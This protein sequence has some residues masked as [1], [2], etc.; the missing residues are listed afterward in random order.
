MRAVATHR[1]SLRRHSTQVWETGSGWRD[2]SR[3]GNSR[4]QRRTTSSSDQSLADVG[5][6]AH[7][8]V[9]VIV[10]HRKAADRHGEDS[11]KFLQATLDPILA[12][13]RSL[14][15]PK[16]ERA[17]HTACNAVIPAG[18]GRIDEMARAMVMGES[19]Q[20]GHS[21]PKV[22]SRVDIALH[23]LAIL[24]SC[25]P[26]HLVGCC[27]REIDAG[28]L[29]DGLPRGF[30]AGAIVKMWVAHRLDWAGEL[31]GRRGEEQA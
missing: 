30:L 13:T 28:D 12:A 3:G 9:Q 31:L 24:P 20:V 26:C 14:A 11:R 4:P 7:Q 17:T 29:D 8:H 10:H 19:P 2:L 6:E 27:G 23:V 18:H 1:E 5:V 16:Q 25:H 21:L 22:V 15:L